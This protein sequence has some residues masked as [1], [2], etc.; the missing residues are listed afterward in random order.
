MEHVSI[1]ISSVTLNTTALIIRMNSSEYNLA[2][3]SVTVKKYPPE[4]GLKPW[5]LRCLMLYR[6]KKYYKTVSRNSPVLFV[7]VLSS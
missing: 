2:R 4:Q 3:V 1:V 6:P 5:T 7:P